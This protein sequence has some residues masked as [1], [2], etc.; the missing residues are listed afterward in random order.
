M[1][2]LVLMAALLVL[3]TSLRADYPERP[4]TLLAGFPAGGLVDS[5]TRALAEGMKKRY[6]AGVIVVNRSGAGGSI[7]VADAV[8]SKPDGYT[9]VLTPLSSLVIGPQINPDLRYR[10]P[11]DYE[12]I[13][14][15]VAYYPMLAVRA[16]APWMTAQAFVADARANP[17][18]MRIGTP[19]EGTSSHLN[20]EEFARV[21]QT[22]LT[23]VPYA[24]WGQSAPA[25]LGGHIEAVVGQP[26]EVR[27]QVDGKK[28]R[29][30]VVYQE[31]R[32]P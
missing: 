30:L 26:G 32:H 6:A 11:D 29:L 25:L 8:H 3:C 4:L 5:V 21:T 24:G 2:Q 18:K 19:G 13:V 27:P 12:P 17:G 15:V 1:K 14:N 7:A 31:K 9:L 10:T 22:K 28:M 20:L 23:H 16:E